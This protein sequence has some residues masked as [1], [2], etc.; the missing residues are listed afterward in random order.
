MRS[1]RRPSVFPEFPPLRE[2][3]PAVVPS[4]RRNGLPRPVGITVGS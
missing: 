4:R 2:L 1:F 3:V